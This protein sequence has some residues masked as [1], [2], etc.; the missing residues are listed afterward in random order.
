ME[1]VMKCDA[2]GCG[3][4]AGWKIERMNDDGSYSVSHVCR[5]HF[6]NPA[7]LSQFDVVVPLSLYHLDRPMVEE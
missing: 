3:R 5:E 2:E 4:K 7:I 6:P 1:E